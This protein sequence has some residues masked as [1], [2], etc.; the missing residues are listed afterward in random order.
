MEIKQNKKAQNVMGRQ[1]NLSDDFLL[2]LKCHVQITGMKDVA[3]WCNMSYQKLCAKLNG[4][5][6]FRER[7]VLL[8]KDILNI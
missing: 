2:S 1:V 4:I 7:E 6:K 8:L 3:R 5:T